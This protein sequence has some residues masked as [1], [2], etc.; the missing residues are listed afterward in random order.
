MDWPCSWPLVRLSYSAL[1]LAGDCLETASGSNTTLAI[2][3]PEW[4]RAGHWVRDNLQ[5]GD[6]VLATTYLPALYYAGQVD[7]WFPNRYTRWERQESGLEGL[8][9]L[10]ALREFLKENPRGYFIAE[11]SRFMFWNRHGDL[12][13]EYEWVDT[14]MT[15]IAEV[16]VDDDICVWRWDFTAGGVP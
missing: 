11:A 16:S 8:D 9:S 14:H 3:H 15:R 1:E 2:K 12:R 5:E 6:A 7:N 10:E 4:R 13:K